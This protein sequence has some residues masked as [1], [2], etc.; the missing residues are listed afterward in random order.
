VVGGLPTDQLKQL[1]DRD[2]EGDGFLDRIL[3]VHPDDVATPPWSSEGVT[4]AARAAWK[5][6]VEGLWGLEGSASVRFTPESQAAWAELYDRHA[7]EMDS[8]DLP[9][10]L[11]NVWSKYRAYA[12]R[13]ALVLHV[14]HRGGASLELDVAAVQ[15]AWRLVKYFKSHARRVY[16]CMDVDQDTKKALRV[17]DILKRKKPASFTKSQLFSWVKNGSTFRTQDSLGKPLALLVE[18]GYLRPSE[19]SKAAPGRPPGEKYDVNPLLAD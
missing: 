1:V 11:R 6:K 4:E 16:G 18:H 17:L 8:P 9:P 19:P 12:G 15:G 10:Q 7:A 3:F 13:L 14:L 2:S 5:E